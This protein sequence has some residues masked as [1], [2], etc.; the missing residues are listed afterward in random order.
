LASGRK[1][2]GFTPVRDAFLNARNAID[3]QGLVGANEGAAS[4]N[5]GGAGQFNSTFPKSTEVEI[6]NKDKVKGAV[7]DAAGRIKRQ[8]G[9]WTNDPNA[10]IEGA[11]QQIK[12]KAEKA[13][14]NV[15]DAARDANAN[16][17]HNQDDTSRTAPS[18]A[19]HSHHNQPSHQNPSHQN[20]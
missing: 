18:S 12:G 14:G 20:H 6:M 17:R 9:E 10:Q 4:G 5:P 19:D 2:R 13:W 15:K 8:A 3:L 11:A 16:A 1:G 7:D